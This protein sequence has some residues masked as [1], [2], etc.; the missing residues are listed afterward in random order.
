MVVHAGSE[1]GF[2]QGEESVF[3]T[4]SAS[5]DY[6]DEMN[7][8]NYLKWLYEK[9]IPNLP[10]RSVLVVD[11]APYHNL[12]EYKFPTQSTRKAEIQSLLKKHAIPYGDKMLKPGLLQLYKLYKPPPSYILDTTLRA[13]GHDCLRL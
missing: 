7:S 5:G 13:H 3:K 11:N 12:Q 2:V 9:S 4:H 8:T 10:Q 6:H 1:E